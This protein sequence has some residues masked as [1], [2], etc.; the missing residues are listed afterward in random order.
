MAPL[1]WCVGM[2]VWEMTNRLPNGIKVHLWYQLCFALIFDSFLLLWF[3]SSVIWMWVWWQM[4]FSDVILWCDSLIRV[5][6]WCNECMCSI[7][8]SKWVPCMW[9]SPAFDRCFDIQTI[10][11]VSVSMYVIH[12]HWHAF[13]R[14][15]KGNKVFFACDRF[16]CKLDR[17]ACSGVIVNARGAVISSSVSHGVI[18]WSVVRTVNGVKWSDVIGVK[19]SDVNECTLWDVVKALDASHEVWSHF[20]CHHIWYTSV[21]VSSLVSLILSCCVDSITCD[22]IIVPF[23][24]TFVR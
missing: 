16:A 2:L 17:E 7:L 3:C 15:I 19:W 20:V 22:D 9:F 6:T 18:Q 11:S 1:K 8:I 4:V 14:I 13:D 10:T 21:V 5:T 23:I 12:I 24:Q